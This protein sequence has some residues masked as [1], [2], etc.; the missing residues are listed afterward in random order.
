MD[1]GAHFGRSDLGRI[2]SP[3][4]AVALHT[5]RELLGC[6]RTGMF[7]E[8]ATATTHVPAIVC[9]DLVPLGHAVRLLHG[10]WFG[11]GLVIPH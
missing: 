8:G 11:Y 4:E 5:L 9:L 1:A 7:H 6:V 2:K 10:L 3:R